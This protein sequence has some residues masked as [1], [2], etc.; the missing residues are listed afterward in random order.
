MAESRGESREPVQLTMPGRN[1]GTLNRGG[2]HS[3]GRP[4]DAFKAKMRSLADRWAQAAEA[5]RVL[6]NPDHPN[7]MAAGRF[8]AEHGYGKP[9][10]SQDIN[11]NVR[12]V[13]RVPV[14]EIPEPPE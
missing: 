6:D 3:P 5:E 8:A 7:W 14:E 2:N 13:I 11:L 9:K 1:G 4:T 12:H 10:E